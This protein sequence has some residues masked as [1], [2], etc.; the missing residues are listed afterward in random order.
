MAP[1]DDKKVKDLLEGGI[2][3]VVDEATRAELERWFGLPSFEELEAKG[4]EKKPEDP[5]IAAVKERRAK[6]LDSIDP[7]LVEQVGARYEGKGE[8]LIQFWPKLE[9]HVDPDVALFDQV[10][11]AKVSVVADP[12]EI[13]RPED[14]E[15][16][17]KDCSPQA[18]L[19]DLHRPETD[20]RLELE[21]VDI[22]AEQKLDIVAEVDK[23][24]KTS[25]KL[26]PLGRSP[27][28]ESRE[29]VDA[30]RRERSQKW[31]DIPARMKLSN[32]RVE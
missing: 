2:E 27:F 22:A 8:R 6:A 26:P 21:I 25:W 24:M 32:R 31:A 23:A 28:I 5:D 19:R 29:L 18:I 3:D 17:L 7:A 11:L 14:I 4:E 10:M 30:A 12:R 13:E 1:E 9:V 16:D 20:F 15:D